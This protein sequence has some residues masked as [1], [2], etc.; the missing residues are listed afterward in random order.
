MK[1]KCLKRTGLLLALLMLFSLLP[2]GSLSALAEEPGQEIDAAGLSLTLPKPGPTGVSAGEPVPAAVSVS[3]GSG[4]SVQS[5]QW[6][7]SSGSSPAQFEAGQQYY[8]EILLAPAAGYAFAG[9]CVV[10]VDAAAVSSAELQADGILRVV[11]ANVTL[12]E[13]SGAYD[14][15]VNGVRVT[16]SNKD[17]VLG[18]GT[19]RYDPS[20]ATLTL[21][22]AKLSATESKCGA[23]ILAQ[24][25]ELTVK[26]SAT[27]DA[28]DAKR[29]RAAQV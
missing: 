16:E 9:D 19:V 20:S 6:F 24:D 14:V 25:L 22:D 5:A 12:A 18:D 8:A 7:T 21:E 23:L 26:G 10:S 4:F 3:S 27:L 13:E 17:D 11:T 29:Y 1:R 15:W 2:L 28:E